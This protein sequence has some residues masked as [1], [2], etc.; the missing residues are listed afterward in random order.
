[1]LNKLKGRDLL[2]MQDLTKTEIEYLFEWAKRLKREKSG[3][4]L[5]NKTLVM[6]FRKASTRTRVSFEVAMNQLSG[7]ALTLSSLES[8]L[9]RGESVEDTA[10][11]LSRYCDGMVIRT[12]AH[13]EVEDFS[14]FANIPVV[15]G[16]SD[17][18]HPCQIISDM[19]TIIEK[20]KTLKGLK[21][22]FIGDG[23]NV[24]NSWILAAGLMG[25]TLA[26]ASPKGY[27]PPKEYAACGLKFAGESGGKIEILNN[28][29]KAVKD[30]DVVYTDV[31]ASMGQ[32]DEH[33][34]RVKAFKGFQ[35]NSELLKHAKKD[36]LVM[37]CLP[38]HREEEITSEVMESGNSVIWDQ[39]E[40]RLHAQKAILVCLMGDK[41]L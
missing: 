40:N 11:V 24:V 32:E 38:A 28:P 31:W 15:N 4:Y 41:L 9:G 6:I 2:S 7:Y 36:C 35:V 16:L 37:H 29:V 33:V 17:M 20:K 21:V 14:V 19:F 34:K 1:M 8:Q 26:V 30:A 23:N 13:K 25:F 18:E 5:K 10:R 12:Y 22:A 39:A 3:A 27:E